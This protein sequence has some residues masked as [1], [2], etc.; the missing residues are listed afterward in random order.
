MEWGV[1]CRYSSK[2]A[3]ESWMCPVPAGDPF[4]PSGVGELMPAFLWL[5]CNSVLKTSALPADRRIKKCLNLISHYALNSLRNNSCSSKAT[6]SHQRKSFSLPLWR[7]KPYDSGCRSSVGS[8]WKHFFALKLNKRGVKNRAYPFL[9]FF[10]L[11]WLRQ[12]F[13]LCH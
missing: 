6:E 12:V 8:L 2:R 9:C 1:Y 7:L 4:L 11:L 10:S 3:T 5:N 13:C